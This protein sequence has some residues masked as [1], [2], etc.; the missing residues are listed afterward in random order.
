[1]PTSTATSDNPQQVY[2][3]YSNFV[4]SV[5][6]PE[7]QCATDL[8][9]AVQQD[10]RDFCDL[11]QRLQRLEEIQVSGSSIATASEG[12]SSADEEPDGILYH[13]VDLGYGKIF[14]RAKADTTDGIVPSQLFVN[15]G[16]GFHVELTIAE[17]KSYVEKRIKLLQKDVL[18]LR[19]KNK[20]KI[21]DHIASCE[22]ILQQLSK[23]T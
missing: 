11:Q 12:E 18:P 2:Q 3:D 5:L 16:L 7:L 15:V 20:Q 9:G 22:L 21:Q 6:R 14:C 4:D 10:I 23:T 1:M 8:E 13:S 19:L 17:A